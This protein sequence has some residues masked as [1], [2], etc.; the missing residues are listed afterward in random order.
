M[1]RIDLINP[2]FASVYRPS[3]ALTQLKSV[4]ETRYKDQ[5]TVDIIYLNQDFARYMGVELYQDIAEGGHY[6]FG[7]GDWF[8]RQQAFPELV[9]NTQEYFQRYY[10]QQ[11]DQIRK[12]KQVIQDKRQGLG[13][14]LDALVTK[15]G[16]DQAKIVGFTSMFSQNAACFALARK[17]KERNHAIV[18]VM[19]GANCE[20]PMGQEIVKHVVQIDFVFSGPGLESFSEFVKCCLSQ[21]TAKCYDIRGVFSKI[22]SRQQPDAVLPEKPLHVSGGTPAK[23][24]GRDMDIEVEIALDYEPFL[25]AFERNF[26][27][28]EIEPVLLFETSRGCWW[29]ER[30]HCTFCGLNG[31]TMNYRA[32]SPQR[33]LRQFEALFKYASRCSS[34][35]C[36]D[37]ILPRN[38][39]K[40]VFP[41]LHPPRGVSLFYEV[42]A[43]L[44]EEEVE[45]LSKASVNS[46]Q[47][48]IEALATS[49]LQLMK[50]GSTVFQNLFLLK[51]CVRYD[52]YPIWN[53]LVGFPGEDEEVYK[54]YLRY[55][56]LLTHLPPPSGVFPVRFDR[57]SP[58]FT[59][60]EHYG[61]DLHPCDFYQLTYPFDKDSL[62]RLAYYFVDH[63]IGASYNVKM[64]KWL[65]RLRKMFDH[66]EDLWCRDDVLQPPRLF[67]KK[68][69][70][71]TVIS[72][73]R[74]GKV[75]EYQLSDIDRHI[76]EDLNRPRRIVD[77]AA[78]LDHIAS[79]D[80]ERE[81]QF[82]QEK[83]LVFNEGE[84]FMSLV[85][86]G[87]PLPLRS[88]DQLRKKRKKKNG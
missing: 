12:F 73:S 72:D 23:E 28:K 63:N 53:L 45:A 79:V 17:L 26:P 50:K 33:A 49:T 8:F 62:E 44:G 87:D 58:Y 42:K 70:V 7:L 18:T 3:I 75:L 85:I 60:Q 9:D 19:G 25:N 78:R 1:Y 41:F 2:P 69:D 43:N 39:L 59:H 27:G 66:W 83:G 31:L 74:S 81:V 51:N 76:L 21:E 29:G 61:L 54:N 6:N 20:T 86:P 71:S 35:E 52:V 57:Y 34:L 68:S 11:N 10:P 77:V 15:Y 37:N 38:Y 80:A 48:G 24:I 36:V 30:S 32:M 47:P 5:V 64:I 4:L 14:Y 82:L 40:E 13:D 16:M 56:P 22:K 46:I 65:G 55:I 67:F 88:F 84:K